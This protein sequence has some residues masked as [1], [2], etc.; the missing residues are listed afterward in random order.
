LDR[1]FD[2]LS[3]DGRHD[4]VLRP[5]HAVARVVQVQLGTEHKTNT[6]RHHFAANDE[7]EDAQ[8]V[9]LSLLE[10]ANTAGVN[11]SVVNVMTMDSARIM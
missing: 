1:P 8:L 10:S 6:R 11:V 9:A 5:G 4:A 3:H 2:R 7:L